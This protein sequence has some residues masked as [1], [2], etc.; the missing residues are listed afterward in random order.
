MSKVFASKMHL[1]GN[2]LTKYKNIN[3][4]GESCIYFVTH[5]LTIIKNFQCANYHRSPILKTTW[6]ASYTEPI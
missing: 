4:Y 2:K 6:G 3:I 5:A 1:S